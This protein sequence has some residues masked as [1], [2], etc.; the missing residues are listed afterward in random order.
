MHKADTRAATPRRRGR[1]R[2]DEASGKA[3]K[4][5]TLKAATQVYAAHG[6][7]RTTVALILQAANI[8]RPT[9]YKLFRDVR[10]VIDLVV[11]Q[12]NDRLRDAVADAILEQQDLSGMLNAGVQAYFNWCREMGPLV[13]PIYSEINDAD[14]P[15]S[16]HRSQIIADFVGLFDAQAQLLGR[17]AADP[18]M[19]DSVLR[20]VEHA[21]SSAFWPQKL[22]EA[23]IERRRQIAM[24]IML[25]SLARPEDDV[26]IPPIPERP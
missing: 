2:A 19:Y 9:F 21:G 11:Q 1:P 8:S 18:L 25:A 23:E 12:A 26:C 20:A 5:Q 22:S 13:G 6:F 3:L 24:R 7:H 10:E 15:A 16:H 4:Q 14:S 17:P